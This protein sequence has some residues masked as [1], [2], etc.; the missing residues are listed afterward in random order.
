MCND[1]NILYILHVMQ[2]YVHNMWLLVVYSYLAGICLREIH[3]DRN[4]SQGAHIHLHLHK[5]DDRLLP[6][7]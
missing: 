6:I 7:S 2:R 1:R 4:S 5:E 3:C